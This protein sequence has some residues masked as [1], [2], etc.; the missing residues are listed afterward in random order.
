[1]P[2]K[3]MCV[4]PHGA[5]SIKKL[6]YNI[7]TP[8]TVKGF[9]LLNI[10]FNKLQIKHLLVVD[11]HDIIVKNNF[12]FFLSDKYQGTMSHC[13]NIL[14]QIYDG[15]NFINEKLLNIK[16]SNVVHT[17]ELIHKINWGS[18]VPLFFLNHFSSR[19]INILSIDRKMEEGLIKNIGMIIFN[20]LNLLE[21]NIAIVFSCDLSHA[22]SK[23]N[24]RFPYN[25]NS[26]IYDKHVFDIL[27]SNSVQDYNKINIE[28]VKQ[29]NTDAHAQLT[30]LAGVCENLEYL[31]K[32]L[33]YE[34]PT[35]F[36]MLTSIIEVH[37]KLI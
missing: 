29:A 23:T 1:M 6:D 34:V 8:K 18:L 9:D 2:V 17:K 24:P 19:T 11:P 10:Y 26:V 36:G 16:H 35:Y 7:D 12:N 5:I 15:S 4:A 33:S 28:L 30:M 13:E 22:H 20:L 25:S 21:E 27:N 37:K 3:L 32:V 31:S 14:E